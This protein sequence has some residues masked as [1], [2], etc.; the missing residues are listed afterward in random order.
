MLFDDA[1]SSLNEIKASHAKNE[2]AYRDGHIDDLPRLDHY[3][4]ENAEIKLSV[5][6]DL[7]HTTYNMLILLQS[8]LF[9]INT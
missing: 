8:Q 5:C 2:A 1:K 7:S 3:V 6:F 4:V 9:F